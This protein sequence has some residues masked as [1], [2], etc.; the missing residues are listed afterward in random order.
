MII[1]NPL[2]DDAKKTNKRILN[3]YTNI[4]QADEIRDHRNSNMLWTD[5]EEFHRLDNA[6][7]YQVLD[8][9]DASMLWP[10]R[11]THSQE[12]RDL[13]NS[14]MSWSDDYDFQTY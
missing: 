9:R 10:D 1:Y 3:D 4:S 5:N 8:Y 7:A 6:Q 14:N 11:I 13:V 2:T 12:D